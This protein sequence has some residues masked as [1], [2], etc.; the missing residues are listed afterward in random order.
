MVEME[1]TALTVR[2]ELK[3]LKDHQVLMALMDR[4]EHQV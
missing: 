2:M 1:S 4:M 3:V